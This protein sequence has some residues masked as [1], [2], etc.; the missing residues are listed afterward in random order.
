MP[1]VA[2]NQ[3]R[4]SQFYLRH[5][6]IPETREKDEAQIWMFSNQEATAMSV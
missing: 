4:A 1:I 2:K 6:A 3:H 5:F